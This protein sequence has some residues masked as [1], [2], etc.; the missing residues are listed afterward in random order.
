MVG[1]SS[2]SSWTRNSAF[3][4]IEH[5]LHRQ[6]RSQLG[7]FFSKTS[8]RKLEQLIVSKVDKLCARLE[9]LP[10]KNE[11][12]SLTHAFVALTLD[13]I[14]RVCFGY[15][16]DT[17]E[18][19]NFA[20][21]WYEDMVSASRSSNLVRHFHWIIPLAEWFPKLGSRR[22]T[23]KLLIAKK[24]RVEFEQKVAAVVDRHAKG[25]KPSDDAFTIFDAILD[26]D[27]PP[28]EKSLARL[29]EEAQT[30]TGAGSITTANALDTTIY[31]LLTHQ[32]CLSHLRKE[33]DSAI[34][35]SSVLPSIVELERLPYLTAVVS[36]G[37]RL[38]KGVPHRLA[39]ISPDVSYRYGNV[40]IPQGVAVSMSMIDMLEDP[41]IFP[42]QHAF[43]PERWLPFDAPEVRHGRKYFTVFGG[44]TRMCIGLNLAWA[45]LY[46][47]VAAMVRRFG[48]R[49]QLHDVVFERDIKIT[50]D[51]FNPLQSRESKGLRTIIIKL[52]VR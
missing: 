17:L 41:T 16:Y 23:A 40:T 25:V 29:S 50:V 10:S 22:A 42:D 15:F 44:G 45:E 24:R 19:D 21:N 35:D 3:K 26:S 51:E 49:L 39:R 18:L 9:K 48:D 6:R 5:D 2:Y 43:I 12:V 28:F 31:Y 30:L 27:V 32:G 34:P 11:P 47:S 52:S 1:Y 33:L 13:I 20:Q 38:S 36:E 4:T 14:S 37:L 46:L 8:I 7:P